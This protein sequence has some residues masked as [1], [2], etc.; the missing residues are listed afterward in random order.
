MNVS[1]L[2]NEIVVRQ[3]HHDHPEPVEGRQAHHDHQRSRITL[4]LS[5]GDK[6]T[7]IVRQAQGVRPKPAEGYILSLSKDWQSSIHNRKSEMY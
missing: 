4:S 1:Q 6:L 7:M 2:A 3:A 5:K